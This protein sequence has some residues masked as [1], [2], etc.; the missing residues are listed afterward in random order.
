MRENVLQE[1]RLRCSKSR[2]W[3]PLMFP[4]PLL[5]PKMH[6]DTIMRGIASHLTSK[7]N[8]PAS[9]DQKAPSLG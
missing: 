9:S 3:L 2:R 7:A 8:V 6:A 4:L 1:S 5:P